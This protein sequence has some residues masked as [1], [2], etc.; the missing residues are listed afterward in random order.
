MKN[1]NKILATLVALLAAGAFAQAPEKAAEAKPAA[2]A[3]EA[4]PAE[5]KSEKVAAAPAAKAEKVAAAPSITGA[6]NCDEL[7]A[8]VTEK[9]EAKGV[10]NFTVEIVANE[11]VKDGKVVGSCGG[12]TKKIVYTK[13]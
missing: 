10:K 6:K 11:D 9:I 5:A 7:K 1:S 2:K 4:K 13:G 8:S 3:T 12:G